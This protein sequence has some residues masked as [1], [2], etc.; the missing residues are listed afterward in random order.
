M[1]DPTTAAQTFYTR[2]AR[3]YDA[4]AR[5]TPGVAR[6]RERVV[7]ALDPRPGETVV[8]LGCGTGANLAPLRE[9]VGPTGR[10]VGL[11]FAPGALAVARERAAAWENVAVVRADAR[12][13]P[14]AAADRALATFVVGMLGDPASAVETWCSLLSA[15]GRIALLDLARTTRPAARPLNPAFRALVALSSP[16][17]TRLRTGDPTRALDRRVVAAHCAVLDRTR[18]VAR[19]T[20]A[21]GFARLVAGEVARGGRSTTG[22]RWR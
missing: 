9:R 22:D 4:V 18:P 2:Y 8:E 10:V 16:P 5:H 3:L 12:R 19:E 21:A 13:P 6:L 11:D 20:R 7:E 17:G 15:G 1:S 14:L